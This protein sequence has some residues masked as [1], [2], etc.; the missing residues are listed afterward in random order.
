MS[1]YIIA[2]VI[3]VHELPDLVS[4]IRIHFI[5]VIEKRIPGVGCWQWQIAVGIIDDLCTGYSRLMRVFGDAPIPVDPAQGVERITRDAVTIWNIG[6]VG[7]GFAGIAKIAEQGVGDKSGTGICIF[8]PVNSEG[9]LS[10]VPYICLDVVGEPVKTIIS[11]ILPP[12]AIHAVRQN[13]DR[14]PILIIGDGE[15]VVEGIIVFD[16]DGVDTAEVQVAIGVIPN[17]VIDF[18]TG[19]GGGQH[20]AGCQDEGDDL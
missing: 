3:L 1:E 9:C 13:S 19:G 18:T 2:A 7:S 11:K 20:E 17:V 10:C 15:H 16:P 5:I 14:V 12:I 6:G 4:T 8:V